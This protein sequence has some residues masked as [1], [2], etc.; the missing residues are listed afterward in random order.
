M[1]KTAIAAATVIMAVL[2]CGCKTTIKW[3]DEDVR[4]PDYSK[5]PKSKTKLVEKYE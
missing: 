4:K 1:I 2:F 5:L 3:M